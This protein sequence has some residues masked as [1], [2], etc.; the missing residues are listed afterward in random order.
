MEDGK[1]TPN[2]FFSGNLDGRH[3]SGNEGLDGRM[4]WNGKACIGLASVRVMMVGGALL[5]LR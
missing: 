5:S 1:N 3:C 4:V 2:F